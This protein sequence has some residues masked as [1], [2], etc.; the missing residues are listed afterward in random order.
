MADVFRASVLDGL[1]FPAVVRDLPRFGP[2]PPCTLGDK[3]SGGTITSGLMRRRIGSAAMT[4]T[5]TAVGRVRGQA[6]GTPISGSGVGHSRRTDTPP[7]Q[8]ARDR[9]PGR[10]VAQCAGGH[11]SKPRQVPDHGREVK[12]I[13]N[14]S[15]ENIGNCRLLGLGLRYLQQFCNWLSSQSI[16]IILKSNPS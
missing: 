14:G 9:S 15:A 2:M 3:P 16:L 6:R 13:Q 5:R 1:D 12:P 7:H 11:W 8:P 10:L 4:H